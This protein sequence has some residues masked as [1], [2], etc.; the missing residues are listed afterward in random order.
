M[1]GL[2]CVCDRTIRDCGV[3]KPS[4][5]M[6][7]ARGS[8]VGYQG[9]SELTASVLAWAATRTISLMNCGTYANKVKPCASGPTSLLLM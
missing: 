7:L 5:D 4:V 9:W 3:D 2:A 6:M 1:S 8:G